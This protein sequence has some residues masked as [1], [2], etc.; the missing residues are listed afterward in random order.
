MPSKMEKYRFVPF[1]VVSGLTELLHMHPM[2]ASSRMY[3]TLRQGSV[4]FT[5]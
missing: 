2:T 4:D 5:I 3:G 1:R